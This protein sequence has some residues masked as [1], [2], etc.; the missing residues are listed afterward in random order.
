MVFASFSVSPHISRGEYL[1]CV[2]AVLETALVIKT[3]M[4]HFLWGS[5]S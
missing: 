2:A 1:L 3:V 4:H 5:G